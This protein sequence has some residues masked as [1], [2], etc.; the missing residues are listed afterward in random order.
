MK[1]FSRRCDFPYDNNRV[2]N[3]LEIEY[4]GRIIRTNRVWNIEKQIVV[5]IKHDSTN[6]SPRV[7]LRECV[8]YV[9]TLYYIFYI[10]DPLSLNIYHWPIIVR[11][12]RPI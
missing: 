10:R 12:I 6:I 4:S 5:I 9:Y 8:I 1:R 3:A 7:R 2:F 11:I